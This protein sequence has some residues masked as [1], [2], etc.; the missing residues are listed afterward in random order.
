ML[1]DLSLDVIQSQIDVSCLLALAFCSIAFSIPHCFCN[2]QFATEL[3]H[4]AINCNSP[5]NGDNTVFLFA[6]VY[7]EQHL[8]CTSHNPILF[9]V[10]KLVISELY[11][12]MQN[13]AEN[14]NKL[15]RPIYLP[16]YWVMI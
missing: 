13:V 11:T 5:H 15:Q 1:D 2:G 7:V 6:S 3:C 14:R 10:T 4:R 12:V 8:K 9:W 16:R